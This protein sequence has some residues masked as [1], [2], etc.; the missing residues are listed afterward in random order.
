MLSSFDS[1]WYE[2]MTLKALIIFSVETNLSLIGL[3]FRWPII[4]FKKLST[5]C[6]QISRIS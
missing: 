1:E 3:M 2:R 6:L 5:L 4:V